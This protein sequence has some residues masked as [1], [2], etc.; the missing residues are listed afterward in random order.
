M[1]VSSALRVDDETL[2]DCPTHKASRAVRESP[3]LEQLRHRN[4]FCATYVQAKSAR[5]DACDKRSV[6]LLIALRFMCPV[7]VRPRNADYIPGALVSFG[8]RGFLNAWYG[9]SGLQPPSERC[10]RAHLATLEAGNV[11]V[12]A[13][14]A[15]VGGAR[16]RDG[17]PV[18]DVDTFHV[19]LSQRESRWWDDVGYPRLER[20]PRAR[21]N[22]KVWARLFGRWRDEA[23]QE[24]FEFDSL[25][26]DDPSRDSRPNVEA[27]L[28]AAAHEL[29]LAS[30]ERDDPGALLKGCEKAKARINGRA[31]W[32]VAKTPGVLADAMRALARELRRRRR[33]RNRGGWLLWAFDYGP[34]RL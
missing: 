9:F 5:V 24:R 16:S 20:N 29:E 1:K 8:L 22:A 6:A 11:L 15:V 21:H 33:I 26:D 34:L 28:D 25:P 19:V 10:L 4:V 18:R 30:R 2:H 14:G 13:P 27:E 32:Q 31:T 23:A 12:R 17:R 3:W 7:G